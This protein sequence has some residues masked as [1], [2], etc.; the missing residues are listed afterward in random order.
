MVEWENEEVTSEPLSIIATDNLVTCAIYA[1]E[2]NLLDLHF[3][4]IARQDK[5]LLRMVNQAKL[6]SY[7]MALCYKCG[8]EVP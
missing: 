2:N 4:G 6:Q 7:C 5:H 8:Y 1:R 3:K